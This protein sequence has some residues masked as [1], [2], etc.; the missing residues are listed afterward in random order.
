MTFDANQNDLNIQ[1]TLPGEAAAPSSNAVSA[2]DMLNEYLHTPTQQSEVW[3]YEQ[4][5]TTRFRIPTWLTVVSAF[6]LGGLM[7]VFVMKQ[8][9]AADKVVVTVGSETIRAQDFYSRLEA[10]AGPQVLNQMVAET[11]TRQYAQQRHALPTPSEIQS[12]AA[13]ISAQSAFASST[14]RPMTPQAAQQMAQ[15][16]SLQERLTAQGVEASDTETRAYYRS[17]TDPR[18][19]NARFLRPESVRLAVI[20]TPLETAAR[21][22]EK[23]LDAGTP[24]A[25]VAKLYSKDRSAAQGG[26]M[27]AF[28]RGRTPVRLVRGLEDE[29]FGLE[30]GRTTRAQK[31]LGAWWIMTCLEKTPGETLPFAQVQGECRREA[32]L[33]K[34]RREQGAQVEA[35][36]AKFRSNV[37]VQV[38]WERYAAS[39]PTQEVKLTPNTP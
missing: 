20:V 7:G 13:Q 29:I 34:A 37:P 22:A 31:V 18:N 5:G 39:V 27:P 4:P 2:T 33:L 16:Q 24:F 12:L 21:Q 30:P 38:F 28:Q 25:S 35:D 32:R 23:A 17:Q 9:H 1:D 36:F 14:Q 15:A 26:E 6:I 3:Q 8:R 10:T 11:L 19:P